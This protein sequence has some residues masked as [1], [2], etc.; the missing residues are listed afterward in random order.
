M[1]IFLSTPE[2]ENQRRRVMDQDFHTRVLMIVQ[3][4]SYPDDTRVF[5]EATALVE[6]GYIVSVICPAEAREK[7]WHEVL[8]GVSTY[9]FA[10]LYHG[11][12]RA[13][14]IWEYAYSVAAM[15]VVSVI[16]LF[17]E[18]FDI[19]HAANPPDLLVLIGAFYK[20]L[21]KQFVYDHHDLAPDMYLARFG[22]SGG[23]LFSVL[24]FFETLSCRFSDHIIA[25]NHS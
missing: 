7:P 1:L 14:Y 20:L 13:S 4:S 24:R 3:N 5:H 12:S 18:G 11:T 15:F 2:D 22:G 17:R 9:R 23:R 19:I 25:T 10:Q 8:N 6:H 21:G 16:V